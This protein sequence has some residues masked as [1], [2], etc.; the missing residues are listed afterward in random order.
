MNFV[1]QQVHQPGRQEG[2]PPD[3]DHHPDLVL[4]QNMGEAIDV[5]QLHV[6]G[7]TCQGG[8][9]QTEYNFDLNS[10]RY[11]ITLPHVKGGH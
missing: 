1:I 9:C 4:C 7:H 2:G 3:D 10:I 6:G 5:N 8:Y 11:K